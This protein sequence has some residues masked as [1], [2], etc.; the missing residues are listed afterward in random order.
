VV[1]M[2]QISPGALVRRKRFNLGD[3]RERSYRPDDPIWAIRCPAARPGWYH[4]IAM[5]ERDGELVRTSSIV[6]KDE[7]EV[8]RP[9]PIYELGDTV[10]YNDMKHTV[11]RDLGDSV[12]LIV[13]NSS[14]PLRGGG[15]LFVA[16]GNT[17]LIAK[18]D[19][20]L[21]DLI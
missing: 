19:L 1:A 2:T 20:L 5:I 14:R 11:S 15:A 12:E 21:E 8:V 18:S 6:G 7:L 9:A 10:E 4:L 16:A 13:P 17:C 3:R